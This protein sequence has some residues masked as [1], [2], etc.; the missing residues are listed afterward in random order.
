MQKKSQLIWLFKVSLMAGIISSSLVLLHF[1]PKYLRL[2][3]I[4]A[5]I[6]ITVLLNFL[7]IQNTYFEQCRFYTRT[8]FRS[9][10]DYLHLSSRVSLKWSNSWYRFITDEISANVWN[11]FRFS[12]CGD[13]SQCSLA[14][15]IIYI[16]SLKQTSSFKGSDVVYGM[17]KASIDSTDDWVHFVTVI[18]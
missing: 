14:N 13:N 1:R 8:W 2:L 6:D 11:E 15:S 4:Y 7:S 9:D 10:L 18:L 12:C 5:K 3:G 16:Y 17:S